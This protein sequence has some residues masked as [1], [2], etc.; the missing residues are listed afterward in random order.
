MSSF[1]CGILG[2]CQREGKGREGEGKGKEREGKG[3][4]REGE[5]EGEGKGK[6][7]EGEGEGEGLLQ[8]RSIFLAFDLGAR[9][10][11]DFFYQRERRL[12]EKYGHLLIN[13]TAAPKKLA[14]LK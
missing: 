3:R 4:E 5:G 9:M 1:L 14:N 12:E 2:P 8:K 7:R 11:K 6:E 13:C 10:A